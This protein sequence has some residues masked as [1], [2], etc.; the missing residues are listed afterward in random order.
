[1][2]IRYDG[3]QYN[4]YL[5]DDGTMDTVISID[6]KTHRFDCEYAS[7][8]RKRNG[9]MTKKGLRELAIEAIDSDY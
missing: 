6:G 9:E 4:V 2:I 1:M 7:S 3:R 8:F 5:E